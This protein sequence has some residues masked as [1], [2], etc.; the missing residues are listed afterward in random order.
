LS[1]KASRAVPDVIVQSFLAS[2]RTISKSALCIRSSE[3]NGYG[4][5]KIEWSSMSDGPGRPEYRGARTG[6]V[7]EG[8]D[9][10]GH[11][12]G[13]REPLK[14][15]TVEAVQ[16][17]LEAARVEFTNGDKPGVGLKATYETPGKGQP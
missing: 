1:P 14:P 17:A 11:T 9:E 5:A 2:P 8:L 15:R 3:R 12:A 4:V 16:R 13:V 10:H 7:G 6:Q